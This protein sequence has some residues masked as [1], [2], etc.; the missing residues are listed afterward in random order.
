MVLHASGL[1]RNARRS[2]RARLA[3]PRGQ[4]G[5]GIVEVMVAF[6]ILMV[7]LIPTASVMA[8]GVLAAGNSV[9]RVAASNLATR[10]IE[11]LKAEPYASIPVNSTTTTAVTVGTTPYSVTQTTRFIPV[12]SASGGCDA[13]AAGGTNLAPEL[14]VEVFVTWPALRGAPPVKQA[15]TLTPPPGTYQSSGNLGVQVLAADGTTP[16]GGIPV[17]FV[18]PAPSSATQVIVTDAN[19]CAFDAYLPAGTY[20]ISLDS[21]GYVDGQGNQNPS[22]T[23]TLSNGNTV[24]TQFFYAQAATITPTLQA[25]AGTTA[26]GGLPVSVDNTNLQPDGTK[27]YAA[28]ATTIGGLFPY[29]SGYT[30]WSGHCPDSDPAALASDGTRLYPNLPPP[31]TVSVSAGNNSPGSVATYPLEVVVLDSSGKPYASASLAIT[32]L[33]GNAAPVD[34]KYACTG[35]ATYE[36]NPPAAL[37]ASSA[38]GVP[39]GEYLLTV[40][41]K[42]GTVQHVTV[43]VQPSQVEDVTTGATYPSGTPIPVKV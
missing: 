43:W 29:P 18:G 39:L 22:A 33:A 7:V 3:R 2:A 28:P 42:A 6:A 23:Q 31:T 11:Q 1:A 10:Q 15:T 35:L 8:S 30:I 9:W 20:D 16:Q 41:P 24:E 36:L 25:A 32:E 4:G 34:A 21:A 17:T 12:D 5:F 26:A 13:P 38:T 27:S 40:T 37:D 19:G 14:L